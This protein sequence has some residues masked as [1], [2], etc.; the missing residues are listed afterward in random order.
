MMSTRH[1][2]HYLVAT[3]VG[4]LV[5]M[6]TASTGCVTAE[7]TI[8]S[9]EF[10]DGRADTHNVGEILFKR[11]MAATFYV[12]GGRLGPPRSLS[13]EQLLQLQAQGNE[14]GGHTLNHVDVTTL[15]RPELKREI[16]DDRATLEMLGFHVTNF[17]YPYGAS[18][19]EAAQIVAECGYQSA[20]V[21]GG[22]DCLLCEDAES[23]PPADPFRMR[24]ALSVKDEHSIDDL[25][26]VVTNVV[27]GG[28]G[29]VQV[30]FHSICD[31]CGRYGAKESL[32]TEWLD[33]LA[34]ERDRGSITI[35]TVQEAL[36]QDSAP[37]KP[38]Q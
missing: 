18:S 13:V 25:K 38:V 6:T 27:D 19:D 22:L 28:G 9:I 23:I 35:L 4:G 7:P 29:W 31:S 17:A 37:P 32:F 10:D 2:S 33:W 8:V 26:H 1:W 16:C 15:S 5:T 12:N 34:A 14:I 21:V 3:I 20:R 11:R 24:T 30:T 36:E